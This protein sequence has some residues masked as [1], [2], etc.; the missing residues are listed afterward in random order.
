VV[1]RL[2]IV[3]LEQ[4]RAAGQARAASMTREERSYAG[5]TKRRPIP[6]DGESAATVVGESP[7]QRVEAA[8]PVA[9]NEPGPFDLPACAYPCGLVGRM[10]A[11]ACG[12]RRQQGP[13]RCACHG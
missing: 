11:K 10:N 2:A 12:F 1:I 9:V 7:A 3:N 13:C 4:V 6:R 8:A 5:K